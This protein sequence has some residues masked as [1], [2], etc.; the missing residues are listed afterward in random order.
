V[1]LI[2]HNSANGTSGTN[3]SN[4]IKHREG[5]FQKSVFRSQKEED[6][7][8]FQTPVFEK[9]VSD[10]FLEVRKK[11]ISFQKSVSHSC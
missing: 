7:R 6:K 5:S 11:K 3:Q 2:Q 4:T 9:D 1:E 10:Q 8:S